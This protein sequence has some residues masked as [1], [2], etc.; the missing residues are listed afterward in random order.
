MQA[1][2][3]PLKTILISDNALSRPIAN[4]LIYGDMQCIFLAKKC[5]ISHTVLKCSR[6]IKKSLL[7]SFVVKVCLFY[8]QNKQTI[9]AWQQKS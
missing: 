7:K 4:D 2:K 9:S 3:L 6:S 8:G 5:Y 1:N